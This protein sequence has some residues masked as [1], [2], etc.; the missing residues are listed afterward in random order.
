MFKSKKYA[1]L[2]IDWKQFYRQRDR[3]RSIPMALQNLINVGVTGSGC[4]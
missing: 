4:V 3:A 2:G 1:H